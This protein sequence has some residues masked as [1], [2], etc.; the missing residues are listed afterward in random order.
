MKAHAIDV[1]SHFF[2]EPYLELIEH[3]GASCGAS[4]DRSNP[5]GPVLLR[6]NAARLLGLR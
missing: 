5:K 6:G 3:E 1:H 2:P 4:V